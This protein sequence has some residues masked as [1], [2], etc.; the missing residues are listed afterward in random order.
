MIAEKEKAMVNLVL[1][2]VKCNLNLGGL[3]IKTGLESVKAFSSPVVGGEFELGV[4]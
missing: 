1:K 4:G 3:G 2:I